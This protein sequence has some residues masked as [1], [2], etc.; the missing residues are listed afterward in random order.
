MAGPYPFPFSDIKDKLPFQ[1]CLVDLLEGGSLI[2]RARCPLWKLR[3]EAGDDQ[4]E[5]VEKERAVWYIHK[6]RAL[7]LLT[8]R[9]SLWKKEGEKLHTKCSKSSGG[10]CV[11]P[12]APGGSLICQS[13]LGIWNSCS[14]SP[15]WQ[16]QSYCRYCFLTV[17]STLP[18]WSIHFSLK[19]KEAVA[20]QV[21][22]LF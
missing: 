6:Q 8:F 4:G 11:F 3:H 19:L 14:S 2:T 12:L 18:M 21:Y 5:L 10:A 13:K 20:H 17:F 15:V 9:L 16:S 22:F 7:L 1:T